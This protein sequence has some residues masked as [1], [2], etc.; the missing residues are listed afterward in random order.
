[1]SYSVSSPCYNCHKREKC[2]DHVKI[3]EA[4]NNIH[5]DCLSSE[6]GHMGAGVIAIQCYRVD[7]VDK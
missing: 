6:K 7:A 4:V 2:T 3:Q 1:M 5:Q